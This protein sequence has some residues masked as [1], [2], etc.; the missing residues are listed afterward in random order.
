M[1]ADQKEQ[2]RR[3]RISITLTGRIKTSET[4]RELSLAHK[5]KRLSAAHRRKISLAHLGLHSGHRHPLYGTH[6]SEETRRKISTARK[7]KLKGKLNP[8]KSPE[9]RAKISL[10]KKGK[11]N[12]RSGKH[13]TRDTIR[14]ISKAHEG[15][16]HTPETKE[17]LRRIAV[18][19]RFPTKNTRPEL[20][21]QKGL[22][23]HGIPF[24]VDV[25]VEGIA[26]ADIVLANS[27][28]A[29]SRIAI[30]VD[31]CY[32]HGCRWHFGKSNEKKREK[33]RTI[34]RQLKNAGWQ[35]H[36]FWEHQIKDDVEGCIERL[37]G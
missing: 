1:I 3:K 36:R 34:T 9:V 37:G 35:V 28:L 10:A 18:E 30:F 13:H 32:W 17:K 20:K 22:V 8:A 12:G 7:G 23:R 24:Y 33:D 11:P 6:R 19:R 2:L 25:P 27:P 14:K 4:R 21:L 5:G 16:S 26:R 31:G 15:L 29:E